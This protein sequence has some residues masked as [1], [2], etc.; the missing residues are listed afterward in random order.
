MKDRIKEL[1]RVRA[2]ELV[3]NDRNWRTHDETQRR[4]LRGLVEEI[5]FA[6]VVLAWE[7]EDGKLELIDG[8]LRQDIS[9][10]EEIPVAVLDVNREEAEK[11]LVMTDPLSAM[12]G[13]DAGKLGD[14][15][16]GMTTDDIMVRELL[17]TLALEAGGDLEDEDGLGGS[18]RSPEAPGR[19]IPAMELHPFEHYDYVMLIFRNSQDFD[20]GT[21]LLGLGKV[22]FK[23]PAGLTKI[24]LGRVID[25]PTAIRKICALSSQADLALTAFGAIRSD[26]SQEPPS[27]SEKANETS[28]DQ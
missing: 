8:H 1:R 27:S 17:D 23:H 3:A 18:K 22:E 5:G 19:E 24:G 6:G 12:A 28:T 7:N 11:L 2:S 20:L 16:A 21:E 26:S 14:L 4:T 13:T 15:L 25:G 9:G 10:E